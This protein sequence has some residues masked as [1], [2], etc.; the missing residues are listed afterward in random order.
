ESTLGA[1]LEGV[2]GEGR[3]PRDA[4]G[5]IVLDE[6]PVCMTHIIHNMLS[7]RATS[8]VAAGLPESAVRAA[9]LATDEAPCLVYT[10]HVVGLP[11]CVPPHPHYVSMIGGSTV[12]EPF[13]VAP[14]GAKIREWVGGSTAEQMTLLY[15][16]TRDGFDTTSCKPPGAYRGDSSS[17]SRA[18][19]VSLIRVS[20]GEGNGDVDSVVGAY[21]ILPWG[22][23]VASK[24]YSI[25]KETFVFML[26]DGRS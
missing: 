24:K 19:T 2:W 21:S 4:E 18:H 15:R 14:L 7:G 6:S 23:G 1:L 22:G 25:P 11:R 16:A 8:P 13:E 26:K 17:S 3:I 10:A 5:R 12:L 20:S 9:A